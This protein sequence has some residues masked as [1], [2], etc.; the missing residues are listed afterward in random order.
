MSLERAFAADIQAAAVSVK[1]SESQFGM[2]D[3]AVTDDSIH[4]SIRAIPYLS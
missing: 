1:S 3:S 2:S 4:L